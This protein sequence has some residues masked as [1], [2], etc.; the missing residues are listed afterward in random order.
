MQVLDNTGHSDANINKHRAGDLYDLI[1]GAP[2]TVKP[3]GEWNQV[4][5]VI[6]KGTLEFYLNGPKI[7][8]TTL[9]DDNWNKMVAGSKFKAWKDFATFKKG[10]IA[11]QDHG[12]PVW[13]RNIKIKK[14]S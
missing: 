4:R 11:L 5:I 2:E 7:V 12:D 8:T 14:L 9:W 10:R 3:V 13:Y 1:A 6:N